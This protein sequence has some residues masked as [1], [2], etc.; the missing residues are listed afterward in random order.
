MATSFIAGAS[1][2]QAVPA[3]RT[4][5]GERRAFSWI[6]FGEASVNER[7]ADA[8]RDRCLAALRVPWRCLSCLAA[9]PLLERDH[10]GPLPPCSCRSRFR[11][12]IRADPIDPESSYRRAARLR[13]L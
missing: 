10:L 7:E 6:C 3:L 12:S 8:Y 2:E 13:P 1:I 5:W 4:L 11:P 9:S